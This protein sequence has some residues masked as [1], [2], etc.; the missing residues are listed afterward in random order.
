MDKK[1]YSQYKLEKGKL[2]LR[3]QD[4]GRSNEYTEKRV[5]VI[6]E[7]CG[8]V[9]LLLKYQLPYHAEEYYHL[10]LLATRANESTKKLEDNLKLMYV[11]IAMIRQLNQILI[12][13]ENGVLNKDLTEMYDVLKELDASNVD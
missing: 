1:N 5:G 6:F 4:G 12:D 11:P 10:L 9:D 3:Y 7:D 13:N 8:T 2:Y